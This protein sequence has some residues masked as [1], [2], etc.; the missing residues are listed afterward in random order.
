[1]EYREIRGDKSIKTQMFEE[2]NYALF[3]CFLAIPSPK[4]NKNKNVNPYMNSRFFM[5]KAF[6]NVIHL[7]T[8]GD[9]DMDQ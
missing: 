1:M 5:N 2:H 6:T 3:C 7:L 8:M 4:V 9:V